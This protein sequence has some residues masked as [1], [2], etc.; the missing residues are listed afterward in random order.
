[1]W[2]CVQEHST[3]RRAIASRSTPEAVEVAQDSNPVFQQTVQTL[4]QLTR[5]LSFN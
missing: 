4:L 5:P 2:M 1:M 3:V